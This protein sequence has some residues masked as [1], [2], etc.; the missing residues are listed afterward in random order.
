[1]PGG[2]GFGYVLLKLNDVYSFTFKRP[3]AFAGHLRDLPAC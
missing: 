2:M 1:M 3:P